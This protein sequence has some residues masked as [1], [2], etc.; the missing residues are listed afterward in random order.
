[1]P[2][3]ARL[4]TDVPLYSHIT[5]A[6]CSLHWLPAKFRINFKMLLL[7]FKATCIYGHAPGCLSDLIA[8]KEQPC[9][10]LC[11]VKGHLKTF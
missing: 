1:M 6:S 8:I 11:S 3:A 4:I 7:T 5:P 9:Y 10:S 2:A